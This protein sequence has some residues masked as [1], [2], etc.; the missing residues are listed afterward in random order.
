MSAVALAAAGVA[1]AWAPL[2]RHTLV[3][4]APGQRQRMLTGVQDEI[5]RNTLRRW[6]TA[7]WPMIVRRPDLNASAQTIALGVPLP[8]RQG[9]RRL[10]FDVHPRAIERSSPPLTVADAAPK[11]PAR[12]AQ[13]LGALA[14]EAQRC[15]VTLRVYGS[16][17]WQALTRLDYLHADS[18]VDLLW[19]PRDLAELDATLAM[20]KRWEARHGMRADGEFILPCGAAVA[21][22]EWCASRGDE[23]VLVKRVG[24]LSLVPRAQVAAALEAARRRCP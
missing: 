4:I 18:D 16:V 5:S 12:W 2:T 6:F 10:G 3:W 17:A 9:R 11:L 22:R 15:G 20:V 14:G 13:S 19:Q 8:P 1:P 21:W 23:R 24:A 7:N